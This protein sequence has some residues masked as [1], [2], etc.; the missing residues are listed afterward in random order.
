MAS[1]APSLLV[2]ILWN[3]SRISNWSL[4]AIISTSRITVAP[5]GT[6]SWNTNIKWKFQFQYYNIHVKLKC[7]QHTILFFEKRR[8]N[9]AQRER[10]REIKHTDAFGSVGQGWWNRKPSFLTRTHFLY[11]LFQA[12]DN[13][14]C[15]Q[16]EK[17]W[18]TLIAVKIESCLVP[19]RV[20]SF[21]AIGVT[22]T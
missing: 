14:F 11:T 15:S 9:V 18:F 5:P 8:K 17:N 19:T 1:R 2:S 3:W 21:R 13:L 20:H 22:L 16:R 7:I 4:T 10:E 12:L 6:A